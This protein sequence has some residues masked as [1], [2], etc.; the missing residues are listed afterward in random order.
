MP[1]SFAVGDSP[2]MPGP[3]PPRST[4]STSTR[5]IGTCSCT[6][7]GGT[8]WSSLLTPATPRRPGRPVWMRDWGS[9]GKSSEGYGDL[10]HPL[11][12]ALL[13]ATLGLTTFAPAP[14]PRPAPASPLGTWEVVTEALAGQP[15]PPT[16]A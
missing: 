8:V 9:D 1:T 12:A 13:T 16:G 11:T 5:A 14:L 2:S 15:R 3:T 6:N 10:M 4:C 7:S